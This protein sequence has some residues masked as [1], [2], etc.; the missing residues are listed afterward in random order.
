MR[1]TKLY[2]DLNAIDFNLKSIK[3]KVGKSV[4]IMPVIKGYAYGTGDVGL[5]GTLLNNEID[6]VAVAL[7][8]EGVNLRKNGFEMPIVVLNQPTI[9]E[10]PY[11]V[12]NKL[13]TGM[14]VLDFAKELNEYALKKKTT[15][16]VH[17]E[18]DTGMGR[19]GLNPKNALEFIKEVKKLKNINVEGIYTHFSSAESSIEYT[20][21]QIEKFEYVINEL[22]KENIEVKYKHACNSTG[23][24]CYENA[25]YNLV[26]PGI[27]IYGY[28]TDDTLK[29]KMELKPSVVLKSKITFLK[30]VEKDTAIS[31]G[32]T[33]VTDK[34]TKIATI[35]LGYADGIRRSFSN[36]G[37]VYI[38]GKFAPI[39]G[40]VCMDSFMVDVTDISNINI[41]DEVIIFDNV[42][43]T[44]EE[45]AKRADT[46][47]YE[48]LSCI[49]N[50]VPREYV[51]L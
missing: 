14:A 40:K 39:I 13:T 37:K 21:S 31:Y 38:N 29:E 6:I 51:N 11:I 35:P 10:I 1:S 33:F 26:R 30:E 47:N 34:H 46:I 49:S 27:C 44:L 16:N 43:I 12:D 23:I 42:H 36:N 25:Y 18:I 19:V 22:K 28:Y 5:K 2:I 20:N 9:E 45:L 15:V 41:G 8:E 32:R 7:A 17:I 24:M 4:K 50:R 3:K 48:I